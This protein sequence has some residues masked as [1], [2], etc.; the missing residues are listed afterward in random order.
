[1]YL[2]GFDGGDDPREFVLDVIH[3]ITGVR[4][5]RTLCLLVILG[6]DTELV[7]AALEHFPDIEDA[8]SVLILPILLHF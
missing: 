2:L 6:E 5:I 7:G 3:N 8:L 1:L 4:G